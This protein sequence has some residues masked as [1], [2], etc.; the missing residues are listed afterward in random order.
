MYG[1]ET[2]CGR[3]GCGATIRGF[4]KI[5]EGLEDASPRWYLSVIPDALG[6]KG[7]SFSGLYKI[8]CRSKQGG[9]RSFDA[10]LFDIVGL[11]GGMCGRR[12]C[13]V[14]AAWDCKER[15]HSLK[16][17]WLAA[18]GSGFGVPEGG[19]SGLGLGVVDWR[20]CVFWV[21]ECFA[22]RFSAPGLAGFVKEVIWRWGWGLW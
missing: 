5:F 22:L 18:S 8:S 11:F 6:G 12:F 4:K 10:L 15:A 13:A 20:L 1:V 2:G 3:T 19:Y 21:L 9:V 7:I 17:R 14:L 16:R